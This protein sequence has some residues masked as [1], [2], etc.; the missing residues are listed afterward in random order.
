[1]E[2]N[3]NIA[4]LGIS[5]KTAAVDVREKAALSESEQKKVMEDLI[6][7]LELRG[8]MTLSTCNRTEIYF[9]DEDPRSKIKD[10]QNFLDNYKKTDLYSNPEYTY[11]LFE[12]DS[13]KHLFKVMA[14]M[15]SQIVGEPQIAGQVKECYEYA[16]QHKTTDTLINKL[17]NYGMQAQ[18]KVRT[19]TFLTDGAVS[20]SFAGVEL[21]RRIFSDLS[22]K[23][24]L[25][26]GAGETAEL[27]AAHF[28]DKGVASIHIANR[29]K[30]KADELA[31]KFKGRSYSL[32]ELESILEKV[33][34]VISATSSTEYVISLDLMKKISKGRHYRPVFLIDLAIP[35]DIDPDI[36]KYDGVFLY[37]LDD[38]NEVVRLNLEKRE[39]EIPKAYKII[40]QYLSEYKDW[41]A[42]HSVGATISR[43]KD[44]FEKI[45]QSEL[46]YVRNKAGDNGFEQFDLLTK[47]MMNK[48]MKHH[49]ESLKKSVSDPEEYKKHK[50]F[51]HK[52]FDLDSD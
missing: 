51:I 50:E 10:I 3:I 26:I 43:L 35:R 15:D 48:V 46:D 45:R 34:I 32:E 41:M 47:S 17:F 20:V 6:S 33:D 7:Q 30:K 23:Q 1:M 18:K 40:D 4:V 52:T 12:E 44:R 14:G 21:A 39:D 2:N 24:V 31:A 42:H 13:V 25:M 38:L 16:L 22:E 19:N 8:C 49:I 29:T 11:T 37:N 27:A 5:H 36:V 28:L 9:S